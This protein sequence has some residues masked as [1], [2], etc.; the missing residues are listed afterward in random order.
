V[1][2][3][4]DAA[5]KPCGKR[6]A[7][8]REKSHASPYYN[9]LGIDLGRHLSFPADVWSSIAFLCRERNLASNII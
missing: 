1:S 5:D 4:K 3:T 9:Q 2:E 8:T 7:R 6:P